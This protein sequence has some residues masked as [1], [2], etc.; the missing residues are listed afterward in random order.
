MHRIYF[1]KDRNGK[2]PVKEYIIRLESKNDKDSRIKLNKI[3]EDSG[4]RRKAGSGVGQP[5]RI[6][7]HPQH[8]KSGQHADGEADDYGHACL[9]RV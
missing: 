9:C 2:E 1:Y 3:R 8:G 7:E 6:R 4:R 5:W